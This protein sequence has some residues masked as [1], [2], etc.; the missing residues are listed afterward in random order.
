MPGLDVDDLDDEN[1]E[2]PKDAG[3]QIQLPLTPESPLGDAVAGS[4]SNT[5][6]GAA[7][8]VQS[9]LFTVPAD[10]QQH[11]TAVPVY[12]PTLWGEQQNAAAVSGQ[13]WAT[14]GGD[15]I[16][17]GAVHSPSKATAA[18]R[19]LPEPSF[20]VPET[21]PL[22]VHQWQDAPS[23][24][25]HDWQG[26]SCTWPAQAEWDYTQGSEQQAWEWN[27][28]VQESYL[29]AWGECSMGED[30]TMGHGP[31]LSWEPPA[32]NSHMPDYMPAMDASR[33]DCMPEYMPAIQSRPK[34]TALAE[35]TDGIS[36]P[37]GH[38]LP[39]TG[40]LLPLPPG[41]QVAVDVAPPPLSPVK[42]K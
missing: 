24:H 11:T 9:C 25:C 6:E 27:A 2:E 4:W 26:D 12:T 23:E 42:P 38:G 33:T 30:P 3:L 41:V 22:V 17:W 19:F 14:E 8:F 36:S 21:A 16:T 32:T 15:Y 5:P 13:R 37:L 1:E 40:P 35:D 28:Q 10:T 39:L 31:L 29:S 18:D 34:R 20:I 7:V